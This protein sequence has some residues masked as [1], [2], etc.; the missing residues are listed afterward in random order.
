MVETDIIIIGAG[1]GGYETAAE[2][3]KMGLRTVIIERGN[4]GGTCLNQ[5]CI[6]T[7]ALCKSA[8]VINTIKDATQFGVTVAGV[9]ASFAEAAKRKDEIVT[10][11]RAGVEMVLKGA[12]IVA[13]EARFVEPH[14]VEVSG[15]CYTA[16][17]IIIATGSAP[18]QLPIEGAELTINSDKLLSSTSLPKSVCVIGGGVIGMEFASIMAA[19][20]TEVTVIEYCKEILPPFDRD[21]SKRLKS[22][23]SRRGI[24]IITSAAVTAVRPGKVVE[25]ESKG[26][27]F[28]IECDEV[29]MAVGRRPV[30]PAGC[31]EVGITI[32][33]RG[34]EVDDNFMTSVPG[35]YA[36][37]DVNGV[38]MLAHAASAQ[39]AAVLGKDVNTKVIPSA[40]FTSPEC[41]MVGLT[42]DA[43]K[44]SGLSIKV[45]KSLFRANGKA[46]TMG[47]V[48][49]M[50]KL[51]IDA[52]THLIL[53]C[54]ILG[55]HAAD[56]VQEVATA[57]ANGL[58]VESIARTVH[59]HP[60]LTEIVLS[61]AASLE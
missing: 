2:A 49:G 13:G 45:A 60:S 52:D 5:G 41:S 21:I 22:L 34:I 48:D 38:C 20:G 7:K 23:L 18:A 12:E 9:D 44:E 51:I 32:G 4:L 42:E 17:K 46:M 16:P 11:L 24:N 58:T 35:V 56:L 59:I 37:G 19:Y 1:P 31:A 3:V 36:I 14:V 33:R 47:D 43:C 15:T 26:K 61:A 29:L 55:A 57:M 27:V 8:E 25:Y 6:P 30:V 40:V 10:T 28:Q 53:G 54:H 39:G 50:V